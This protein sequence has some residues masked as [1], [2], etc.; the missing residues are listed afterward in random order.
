MGNPYDIADDD[1]DYLAI[2]KRYGV[3][4]PQAQKP[5]G[6]FFGDVARGTG[7]VIGSF[8]TTAKDLG[9][10]RIG[11]A[12][13]SYGTG[14]ARRNPAEI[15]TFADVVEK[16]F[17]TIREGAGEMLPQ[18][19]ANIGAGLAG[20]VI[21]GALGSFAG[22]VGTAAGQWAGGLG[23]AYLANLAQEYGSIRQDQAEEG[24]DKP[25]RAL[26][27]ATPA[28]ALD[29][30]IGPEG[31]VIKNIAKKGLKTG[32]AET[33][34][35]I[36][37]EGFFKSVG[38]GAL[39][40]G[41]LTEGPQTAMERW[42]AEKPLNTGEAWDEYAVASAKAAAGGGAMTGVM[43]PFGKRPQGEKPLTEDRPTN[44]LTPDMPEGPAGTQGELFD[45]EAFL[46]PNAP[47]TDP[48]SIYDTMRGEGSFAGPVMDADTATAGDNAEYQAQLHELITDRNEIDAYIKSFEDAGH[49]ATNGLF[50]N[51][52]DLERVEHAKSLRA[53]IE[54]RME[55]L[56]TQF[57]G[58]EYVTEKPNAK[59]PRTKK[60]AT[61]EGATR[62]EARAARTEDAA[63]VSKTVDAVRFI[64][65]RKIAEYKTFEKEVVSRIAP[66]Q[67]QAARDEFVSRISGKS[68]TPQR[69]LD[70]SAPKP[71]RFE[72]VGFGTDGYGIGNV[73]SQE[74]RLGSG[75][76]TDLLAQPTAS[77]TNAARQA[78]RRAAAMSRIEQAVSGRLARVPY[79]APVGE[80]IERGLSANEPT[81][82]GH[83]NGAT[84]GTLDL[85][86]VRVTPEEKE[87]ASKLA[88][89]QRVY[90]K[91]HVY[92]KRLTTAEKAILAQ[93]K[94]VVSPVA[95]L[96]QRE[97]VA[98]A[99][100]PQGAPAASGSALDLSAVRGAQ[101][102][103]TPNPDARVENPFAESFALRRITIKNRLGVDLTEDEQAMLTRRNVEI[104]SVPER[105]ARELGPRQL[106]MFGAPID[107][108][109]PGAVE[110]TTGDEVET[111]TPMQRRTNETT[112]VRDFT[113]QQEM[114]NEDGS[115]TYAA[116]GNPWEGVDRTTEALRV[117]R[118]SP[119]RENLDVALRT[120]FAEGL[121]ERHATVSDVTHEK[122]VRDAAQQGLIPKNKIIEIQTAADA[123]EA[124]R[125]KAQAALDGLLAIKKP[126][127]AD[128]ASMAK[129]RA[130]IHGVDTYFAN[131]EA[132][133]DAV[134][135]PAKQFAELRAMAARKN[136][137]VNAV[138]I[139]LEKTLARNQRRALPKNFAY[140]YE[141][142]D[143]NEQQRDEIERQ[144]L[145]QLAQ[146]IK[147]NGGV[148]V[149]S[150]QDLA[151]IG[152][153]K[154]NLKYGVATHEIQLTD[155]PVPQFRLIAGQSVPIMQQVAAKKGDEDYNPAQPFVVRQ[156]ESP[157]NVRAK[158]LNRDVIQIT[159]V[160]P[161]K[162]RRDRGKRVA[163]S[164]Q[165]DALR[166]LSDI[167]N[168]PGA[169]GR[170]VQM[171]TMV[172]RGITYDII[173]KKLGVEKST[174]SEKLQ[175][176]GL[177][178]EQLHDLQREVGIGADTVSFAELF[179]DRGEEAGYFQVSDSIAGNSGE[180][181]LSDV[182]AKWIKSAEAA[183]DRNAEEGANT[184]LTSLQAATLRAEIENAAREARR[185]EAEGREQAEFE[186]EVDEQDDLSE[187]N[188]EH[189]ARL[190]STRKEYVNRLAAVKQQRK[191]LMA[192]WKA[193]LAEWAEQGKAITK[194]LTGTKTLAEQQ[195]AVKGMAQPPSPERQGVLEYEYKQDLKSLN[196][197]IVERT[198]YLTE[199]N[200]MW[201]DHEVFKAAARKTLNEVGGEKRYAAWAEWEK[202][203]AASNAAIERRAR[204]AT[205]R[206]GSVQSLYN[207]LREGDVRTSAYKAL[208]DAG[209]TGR[210]LANTT[211]DA[212]VYWGA[213]ENNP[214]SWEDLNDGARAAAL[215]AT[216]AYNR[217]VA[218][219]RTGQRNA[220]FPVE[221]FKQQ[222]S[223]ALDKLESSLRRIENA[224][225]S[226]QSVSRASA[227]AARTVFAEEPGNYGPDG[228]IRSDHELGV[229]T[230]LGGIAARTRAQQQRVSSFRDLK[231]L[232]TK[233]AVAELESYG[234]DEDTLALIA[235]AAPKEDTLAWLQDTLATF[236]KNYQSAMSEADKVSEAIQ[237]VEEQTGKKNTRSKVIHAEKPAVPPAAQKAVDVSKGV[238]T[239]APIAEA[240]VEKQYRETRE[241]IARKL[242]SVS[243][244]IVAINAAVKTQKGLKRTAA[245][246]AR[247]KE[248]NAESARLTA[249]LSSKPKAVAQTPEDRNQKRRDAR[250]AEKAAA[251]AETTREIA[252]LLDAKFNALPYVSAAP[253]SSSIAPG[254]PV[255]YGNANRVTGT[256]ASGTF[257]R[258]DGK[259][260]VIAGD[261]GLTRTL[262][263][264]A[265]RYD[266]NN[267]FSQNEQNGTGQDAKTMGD[268]LRKLFFSPARF[269]KL[270]TIIQSKNQLTPAQYADLLTGSSDPASVQ[271]VHRNGHIYMFADN[272]APGRELAVFLHELGVHLGMVN[273]LG[274]A[275]YD[276]LTAQIEQWAKG[277]GR[278][279]NTLAKRALAR[280]KNAG[281]GQK[282]SEF[283]AYFV[284]EAILRGADPTAVAMMRE[285]PL[286]SWLRTVVAAMKSA[287]RR[288]G[289]RN[290]DK[291]TTQNIIDMAYGAA[292]LE[293][294]DS[295]EKAP[296]SNGSR[297]FSTASAVMQRVT[298]M[299]PSSKL[300][301]SAWTNV[302]D[303][304][305]KFTPMWL[306]NTQLVERFGEKL[307]SL[308]AYVHLQQM[309]DS[310]RQQIQADT[311][312]VMVKWNALDKKTEAALAKLMLEA[313]TLQAHPD[314]AFTDP[315]NAHLKPEN[316]AAHAALAADWNALSQGAKG[317]YNEARKVLDARWKQ[318]N[319]AYHGTVNNMYNPLIAKETDAKT[320]ARLIRNRDK[321]HAKYDKLMSSFQGPYFP[322][323]R[324][325]DYV[326]VGM[327]PKYAALK[328]EQ[329]DA[330][331]DKLEALQDQIDALTS[332]PRH[333]SVS[334]YESAGEA[335]HAEKTLR[336]AEGFSTERLKREEFYAT[337]SPMTTTGFAD[338]GSAIDESGFDTKT[339]SKIK[340]M[341]TDLFISALPEN[342]A[343]SREAK[344]RNVHGVKAHEMQ[345]TFAI[346]GERDAF[347]ISRLKHSTEMND[348]LVDMQKEAKAEDNKSS[349]GFKYEHLHE[350]MKARMALDMTFNDNPIQNALST[351]SWAYHLGV[352]PAFVFINS[353]QP[354]LV[355]GPVLAG[356]F[357]L[358]PATD[359]LAKAAA[360]SFKILKAART[361]KTKPVG[362]R[363]T[364]ALDL[365]GLSPEEQSMAENLI[366][367]RILDIG[368]EHDLSTEA[369]GMNPA[370]AK[371]Q[372]VMSW[373]TQQ[374]EL[375][376][377][378]TTSLA[379]YRLAR[380]EKSMTHDAAVD[381][382][383]DTT[384]QTQFDYNAGNTAR[385][386][387]EGGP[388]P[389][390]KL[391]FQFRRYQQSMLY[392]LGKNFDAAF[393]GNDTDKDH[394]RATLGYLFAS[395]GLV[396][397]TLGVPMAGV[398]LALAGLGGDGDDEEGSP[399]VRWR[400]MLTKM[401]GKDAAM[402]LTDG[403]PTMFGVNISK[404]IGMGD[405]A[406][407]FPMAKFNG[408]QGN[409][410]N[411]VG[412]AMVNVA[413]APAN[414]AVGL[415]DAKQFFA[416]GQW[417]K[418]V[419]KL[420]QF[421]G[422][423]PADILRAHRFSTEGMTDRQGRV[424][425]PADKFTG[426]DIMMRAAGFAPAKESEYF[427]ANNAKLDVT[428]AIKERRT[429]LIDRLALRAEQGESIS[430]LVKESDVTEFNAK[431]NRQGALG[432]I[433]ASDIQ[434]KRIADEK[435]PRQRDASGVRY[436][437]TERDFRG[438]TAFAR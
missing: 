338:L 63:S 314:K 274:K 309:A 404:R 333:Y 131:V 323:M 67:R 146:L 137:G 352:S 230:G 406:S 303:A 151:A 362:E 150:E 27:A 241:E 158:T 29:F 9:A 350:E 215:L 216:A 238:E 54:D 348:A 160:K 197:Q 381:Y 206:L 85:S 413:G 133:H 223:V 161:M 93:P 254:T 205:P 65:P 392:L 335:E 224:V 207:M 317:T 310:T 282:K 5:K 119:T 121:I 110:E 157:A 130:T 269:D 109:A 17:T 37:K 174:V 103:G 233:E 226:G 417:N 434:K 114:F 191:E 408:T 136:I 419:E 91:K 369:Q 190:E 422:K 356:R 23:G 60:A 336:T 385:V 271:A 127:A 90:D 368:M 258:M 414:L 89:W 427:L 2:L 181:N 436:T 196:E 116:G 108:T 171:A 217:T 68:S 125:A 71:V 142:L 354:W 364:Q 437:K 288:L 219:L 164:E 270:V 403:I 105:R 92:R 280:A 339:A 247:L 342:S 321:A 168:L 438:L 373:A 235:R 424:I 15:N 225:K 307:K 80:L 388:V 31:K 211:E 77:E 155:E 14:L 239:P 34:E 411:T 183:A 40:E 41:P 208:V 253:D 87:A 214:V 325:G 21:G 154:E 240:P 78:E 259:N 30:A 111:E 367:R 86:G 58:D 285:G 370:M 156:V 306:T 435:I 153:R 84:E 129:L 305:H 145:T 326:V 267:E 432:R 194:A 26:A 10:E 32:L 410:K 345:R 407:P 405:V 347:Y 141:I 74:D 296:L 69:S 123:Q 377:R 82:T 95:V 200:E 300:N 255:Y 48:A 361:D 172:A 11:G 202:K 379:A 45:K 139:E 360:D 332:D 147:D 397:G 47:V 431:H 425:V 393:R 152:V 107:R 88:E 273:L 175:S 266:A 59:A 166:E 318:R 112:G 118:A 73:E 293:L 126:T 294:T 42:G 25:G 43:H 251:L 344:R 159:G 210:E 178:A 188:Q 7:Q 94:P 384:S 51:Q 231:K 83:R 192:S 328:A 132:T 227:E 268:T 290:T 359:A 177:T 66:E 428:M 415:L 140:Q 340:A 249:K 170:L 124:T 278:P 277:S 62:A 299:F 357:G 169:G 313:T 262:P 8:G 182:A 319:E 420:A 334:S 315:A 61:K 311:Q 292:A 143:L 46:N 316:K 430:G 4:P 400:N 222:S 20:R 33:A 378:L 382:A 376:N 409:S 380:T 399:E 36:A 186:E 189:D 363:L 180:E 203:V 122:T 6:G 248:L 279:E 64:D 252:A 298:E 135:A 390:A 297:D 173:A 193:T 371:V 421:G 243:D 355:T 433:T 144:N 96:P 346:S 398:A 134:V 72:D 237:Q 365:S 104:E 19:P 57:Y 44:L 260:V 167:I 416:S 184:L 426:A 75:W 149:V 264:N 232:F 358:K 209:V 374:V 115:A 412:Q 257:L 324:I 386:M 212:M 229:G 187:E 337:L 98:V 418:G 322:M 22:P 198:M 312:K 13:E 55:A 246:I 302:K 1:P 331:G 195:K 265:V 372:R 366:R 244:E 218:E 35:G 148:I 429:A 284:E 320:K 201:V 261:D 56:A 304:W 53:Q 236:R 242:S 234:F 283:V 102:V 263:A 70:F 24:I 256:R 165:T 351:L 113:G 286:K 343:L 383:Y 100:V 39:T 330:T 185:L 128:K 395:Q 81:A 50:N 16:P 327:S 375:T 162:P 138:R 394:A 396:A 329:K 349:A 3:E 228:E 402:V 120:A 38:K 295:T 204:L 287:M 79:S 101:A 176:V 353:T 163:P 289:F 106:D 423:W 220:L 49:G 199:L 52:E 76:Q 221:M 387:R 12:M 389:M 245:Q 213:L 391:I 308:K 341:M 281:E 272:I 28:A 275:K 291:L 18:L 276:Q 179:G 250:A 97:D 401:V 117:L 301:S 99:R